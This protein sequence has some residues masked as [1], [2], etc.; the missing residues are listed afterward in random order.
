MYIILSQVRCS[1]QKVGR[2]KKISSE[3]KNNLRSR[4]ETKTTLALARA[5]VCVC[6]LKCRFFEA[7]WWMSVL[8]TDLYSTTSSFLLVG[9]VSF[10]PFYVSIRGSFRAE[11]MLSW[12]WLIKDLALFFFFFFFFRAQRWGKLFISPSSPNYHFI[13]YESLW[14]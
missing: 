14:S 2:G 8:F 3:D 11:V 5:C 10:E 12:G 1:S 13:V 7:A 6:V 4:K 9:S